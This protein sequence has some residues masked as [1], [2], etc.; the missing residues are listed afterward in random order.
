MN[1]KYQTKYQNFKNCGQ[2]ITDFIE[3]KK[4]YLEVGSYFLKIKELYAILELSEQFD[5]IFEY[6][7]KRL[8]AIKD[9]YDTSSQFDN[10]MSSLSS[11]LNKNEEKFRNILLQYEETLKSFED[12]DKVMKDLAEIDKIIKDNLI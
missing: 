1:E 9:I 12:L 10:L 3:S 2:M 7:K 11:S 8:K 4:E 5:Q 6:F